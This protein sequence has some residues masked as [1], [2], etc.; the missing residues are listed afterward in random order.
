MDP[1]ERR[2]KLTL[3]LIWQYAAVARRGDLS[4]AA[5]CLA[6]IGAYRGRYGQARATRDTNATT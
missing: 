6:L 5:K 1:T 2:R 3:F 4:A